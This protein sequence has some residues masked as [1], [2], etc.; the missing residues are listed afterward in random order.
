M[1]RLRGCGGLQRPFDQA[2]AVNH[3]LPPPPPRQAPRRHRKGIQRRS[4]NLLRQGGRVPAARGDPPAR[5]RPSR[6]QRG[7][8]RSCRLAEPA[9]R[10]TP[11]HRRPHEAHLY[12]FGTGAPHP[13]G[14]GVRRPD[15]RS[16][17]QVQGRQLPGQV[18]DQVGNGR[19]R[20]RPPGKG[21]S[22]DRR[23]IVQPPHQADGANR[24]RTRRQGGVPGVA[25]RPLGSRSWPPGTLPHQVEVLLGD[26]CL[27]RSGGS[28]SRRTPPEILA[29]S[30]L[31]PST[32]PATAGPI[33]SMP[34]SSSPPTTTASRP[35][36]WH[37]KNCWNRANERR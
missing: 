28:D 14:R 33:P 18:R 25:P 30:P 11:A 37:G 9:D 15:H 10:S 3:D 19:F 32:T 31:A 16:N 12:D 34:Q 8:S 20:A 29:T 27:P 24:P 17:S 22:S 1:L 26:L 23:G 6:R 21:P 4:S 2:L 7:K 5:N 13:L 35:A 36:D